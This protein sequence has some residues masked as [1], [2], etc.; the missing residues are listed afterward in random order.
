[1][2]ACQ[3]CGAGYFLNVGTCLPCDKTCTTCSGPNP[4]NC[5]TCLSGYVFS[6][7]AC[8]CP[9]GFPCDTCKLALAGCIECIYDINGVVDRCKTCGPGLYPVGTTCDSCDISCLTCNSDGVCLTCKATYQLIND[10]CA[11]NND[12]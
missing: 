11:C 1:M 10:V 12:K 2:T 5:L 4:N 3:S 8:S 7:G 6:A 9:A